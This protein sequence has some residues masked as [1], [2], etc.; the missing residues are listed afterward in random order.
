MKR[1]RFPR[2]YD[3]VM[4]NGR[5]RLGTSGHSHLGQESLVINIQRG[6]IP[7]HDRV[8]LK[9][10]SHGSQC[11]AICV[12]NPQRNLMML[13]PNPNSKPWCK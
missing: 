12:V 1:A 6:R 8:W 10:Y 3:V 4:P 2:F 13:A 7:K 11:C 9:T 5:N